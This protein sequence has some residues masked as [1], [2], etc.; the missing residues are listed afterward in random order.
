MI[1]VAAVWRLAS[2]VVG[3]KH[4][5][6][7]SAT[8]ERIQ[9]SVSDIANFQRD[10]QSSKIES[11]YDYLRQVQHALSCGERENAV[12]HRLESI[13]GEMDAIQ[14]HMCKLFEAS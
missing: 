2:I 9:K 8:L 10:E 7:I 3:Q 13:E 6:D 4:L 5:A 14:R 12:R 11:A 1:D